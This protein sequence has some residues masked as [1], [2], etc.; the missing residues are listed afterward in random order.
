MRVFLLVAAVFFGTTVIAQT[1]VIKKIELAGENVIVHYEL[2][3]SNPNNEYLINLYSSKDNFSTVLTKVSGD[4]GMEVK[5][6][7]NKKITW[8]IREEYGGYKGKIALEIRGKV[9]IPFA[10]L[11]GFDTKKA[12]KKGTTVNLKWKAAG[13]TPINIELYKG[14]QRIGGDMN[15]P[16][17]G[18]HALFIPKH[19]ANGKDYRLKLSDT[20]NADEVIYSDYF[21]VTPKIPMIAKIGAGVAVAAVIVVLVTKSGGGSKD[22]AGDDGEDPGEIELPGLP[23]DN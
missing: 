21:K 1:V 6:G 9:Y 18:S 8:K 4:V 16:N 12:Y 14:G 5:P 13:S 3:D 15:I 23:G 22:N 20:R 17:N 2:E 19:A 7:L 10:K 11:Q